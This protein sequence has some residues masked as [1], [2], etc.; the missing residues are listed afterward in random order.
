MSLTVTLHAWYLLVW[1]GAGA[2]LWLPLEYLAWRTLA[3][4]KPKFWGFLRSLGRHGLSRAALVVL[5]AW[6]WAIWECLRW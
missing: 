4:P 2:V 1:V 3:D 5:V 6:P